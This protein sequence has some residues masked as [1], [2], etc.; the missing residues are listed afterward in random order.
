M[1]HRKP[2]REDYSYQKKIPINFFVAVEPQAGKR[3]YLWSNKKTGREFAYF[4]YYLVFYVY[5]TVQVIEL[6]AD[7]FTTHKKQ[8]EKKEII[9]DKKKSL[10]RRA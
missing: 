9:E 4:C 1:F 5:P 10:K 6:V 8:K 7:N 2:L 3:V